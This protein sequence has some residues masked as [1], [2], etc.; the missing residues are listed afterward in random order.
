MGERI[1]QLDQA[2]L[3]FRALAGGGQQGKLVVRLEGWERLD[4]A[5]PATLL[6]QQGE[7]VPV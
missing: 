3:A 6:L 5:A 2:E 1:Y 7:L 4:M